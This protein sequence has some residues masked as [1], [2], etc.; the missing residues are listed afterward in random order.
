MTAPTK[1]TVRYVYVIGPETGLQKV[2]LATNP[3][4]RL[5]HLQT[6]NPL[7]LIL[8]ASVPVPFDEGLLVEQRA[9]RLLVR[10]CIRNEWFETTPEDAAAA[11]HAAVAWAEQRRSRLSP[12]R[13]SEW[14]LRSPYRCAWTPPSPAAVL[15]PPDRVSASLAGSGLPLFSVPDQLPAKSLTVAARFRFGAG[16]DPGRQAPWDAR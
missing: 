4:A 8:H 11:V 13:V 10:S 1:P 16:S 7:D 3:R 14:R 12:K 9:H 15:R 6:G 5:A 2:G